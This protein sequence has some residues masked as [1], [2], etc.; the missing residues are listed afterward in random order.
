MNSIASLTPCLTLCVVAAT[1]KIIVTAQRV[2]NHATRDSKT[3]AKFL[4]LV[5]LASEES[6]VVITKVMVSKTTTATFS[7]R[8]TMTTPSIPS[9][10]KVRP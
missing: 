8:T 5:V 1:A 4:R 10:S 7:A 9:V 3:A 6:S 2:A